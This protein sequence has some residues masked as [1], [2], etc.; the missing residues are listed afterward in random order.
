PLSSGLFETG[1]LVRNNFYK[2]TDFSYKWWIHILSY[3]RRDQLS[4]GYLVWREKIRMGIL[5]GSGTKNIFSVYHPHVQTGPI[6]NKYI[7]FLVVKL[8]LM[9]KP[10]PR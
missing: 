7:K 8:I 9:I 4:L 10:K 1:I 5:P 3:S 6:R 2:P